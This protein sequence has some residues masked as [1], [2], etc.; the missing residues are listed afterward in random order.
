M[1][2]LSSGM[3]IAAVKPQRTSAIENTALSAAI[4]MSHAAAM[5]MPPPKQAP[6][7]KARVGTGRRFSRASPGG[8]VAGADIC[9]AAVLAEPAQPGEI[10]TRLKV[11]AHARQHR[12]AQLLVA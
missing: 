4:T 8:R 2:A 7:T 5:P 11:L 12:H 1:A 9:L 6:C 3:T 10:G